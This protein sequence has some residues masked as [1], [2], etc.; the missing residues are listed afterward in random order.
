M[1]YSM[2]AEVLPFAVNQLDEQYR[3]HL[4]DVILIGPG[5]RAIFRLKPTD[6]LFEEKKGTDIV[7]EL[8]KMKAQR[9]YII[10]DDNPSSL[11]RKNLEGICDHD[12]LGGGHHFGHDYALLSNL[13]SRRLNLE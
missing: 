3:D 12:F 8:S 7:A 9:S 1:G 4:K 10:C 11:C 5:Q 13:I 2:G 6:Y